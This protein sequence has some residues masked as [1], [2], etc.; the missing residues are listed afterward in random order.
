MPGYARL[1][2]DVP[3]LAK[4][5]WVIPYVPCRAKLHHTAVSCAVPC[6]AVPDRTVPCRAELHH[7]TVSCAVPCQAVLDPTVPCQAVLSHAKQWDSQGR[8]ATMPRWVEVTG[9]A[10][11]RHGTPLPSRAYE[12]TRQDGGCMG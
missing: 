3:S 10:Q 6:Q 5:C 9:M 11:V 7:T 12:A 8:T 1:H 4:L 2:Q